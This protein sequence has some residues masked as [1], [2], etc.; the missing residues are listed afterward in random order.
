MTYEQTLDY[1]YTKL[2]MYQ[3]I[4]KQ[5]FKKDLTNII[6]LCDALGN[7]QNNFKSIHIAGT[8]GKGSTAHILSSIYQNNGYKVGLYTSPHLVDFR[9]RIKLNGQLCSKEFVIEFTESIQHLIDD[10][11][12]SFFEITVAMAFSYFAQEMVDIA[13]IETGLGGRLDSTNIIEPIASI[14]TSI[15]FDHMDMLG[16]TLT[17][18]ADEKAGIIKD[19]VPVIVG[20]IADEPLEVI[21]NKAKLLNAPIHKTLMQEME[22]DLLGDYQLWNIASAL[23]CVEVINNLLPTEEHKNKEALKQVGSL[24]NFVGRWQILNKQPLVICDV[25]HNEQGFQLVAK[26]LDKY[27]LNIYYILGFVQEKD[28]SSII[29]ILPKGEEYHFVKPKVIR[30]MHADKV[31]AE[32]QKL[33]INGNPHQDLKDALDDVYS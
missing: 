33:G 19:Q 26:E 27:N 10:I 12:P 15:G 13:I 32:F 16:N 17:A 5:A 4:G 20:E 29:P 31:Q 22:T 18:I 23:K 21:K 28:L 8:N 9:E 14:I 7:P 3:R 30:G 24:S 1:L 25:G 11:Q 2:P 6:K